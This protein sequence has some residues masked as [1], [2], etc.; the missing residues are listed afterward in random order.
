MLDEPDAPPPWARDLISRVTALER[1]RVVDARNRTLS[2]RRIE[3]ALAQLIDP[4]NPRS[5]VARVDGLYDV[6]TQ[7]RGVFRLGA[8]IV[9]LLTA[10][11]AFLSIAHSLRW[12]S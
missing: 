6:L 7:I 9:I 2:Q 11:A 1:H 12:I 5:V 8:G 3:K 4:E 10:I